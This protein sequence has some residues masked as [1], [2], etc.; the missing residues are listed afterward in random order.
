[1]GC[2]LQITAVNG[3]IVCGSGLERTVLLF[4]LGLLKKQ[5]KQSKVSKAWNVAVTEVE[6]KG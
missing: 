2:F 5:K 4:F 1:M 3:L 6:R